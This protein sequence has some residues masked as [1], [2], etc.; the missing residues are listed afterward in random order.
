M[1]PCAGACVVLR[2]ADGR[3]LERSN[4]PDPTLS[5]A[6]RW[7]RS[8]NAA[9]FRKYGLHQESLRP[10]DNASLD[11]SIPPKGSAVTWHLRDR[12]TATDLVIGRFAHADKYVF[13]LSWMLSRNGLTLVLFA[14]VRFQ[15][16]GIAYED[17]VVDLPAALA[18]LYVDATASVP[19]DEEL[20]ARADAQCGRFGG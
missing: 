6:P 12:K 17:A 5:T 10:I 2:V 8:Q 1:A 15:G 9:L 16:Q 3:V 18:L 7:L 4:P 20:R 11:W 14:E 13:P 19:G